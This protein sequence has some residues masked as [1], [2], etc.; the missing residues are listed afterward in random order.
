MEELG[1][2]YLSC[3]NSIQGNPRITQGELMDIVESVLLSERFDDLDG[4][5]VPAVGS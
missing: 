5:F 2:P 1:L 3:E 4:V